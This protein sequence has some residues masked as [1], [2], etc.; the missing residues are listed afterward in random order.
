MNKEEIRKQIAAA[1]EKA[2]EVTPLAPSITNTVTVNLVA[3]AQ[4]A[5][6]GSAA[7]VYMADEGE[8]LA[9]VCGGMYINMGTIFPFYPES[10]LATAKALNENNKPWVVDPVGL[11]LGAIRTD[12]LTKFKEYKPTIIRGNASEI[13]GVAKLWGLVADTTSEGPRGVDSVDTVQSAQDAA[14]AIAKFTGGAVA[15]SGKKDLITDGRQVIYAEGGSHFMEKITGAGCS[16]G[17][18][19]AVYAAVANPFV[20][21]LTASFMYNYAGAE[22]EKTAKG[23]ASFQVDFLDNLYLAKGDLVANM[24]FEVIDL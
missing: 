15:V 22:A 21:A 10:L 2:R 5:V 12:I 7:M 4:L 6:G 18:V 17:G 23:P 11:G 8:G 3:N 20:A 24:P 13:I 14:V 19:V 1:V 16:L 9:A